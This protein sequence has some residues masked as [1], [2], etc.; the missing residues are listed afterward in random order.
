MTSI[1]QYEFIG[2][3]AAF[4]ICLE[5]FH[6]EEGKMPDLLEIQSVRFP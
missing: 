4:F 5:K 2:M 3:H 6:V 1:V